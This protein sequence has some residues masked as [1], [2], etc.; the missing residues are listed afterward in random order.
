MRKY[1]GFVNIARPEFSMLLGPP[2]EKE[3]QKLIDDGA[4]L[5]DM[6]DWN[7]TFFTTR[8]S[9]QNAGDILKAAGYTCLR[10]FPYYS[11]GYGNDYLANQR[12]ICFSFQRP[13]RLINRVVNT[14]TQRKPSQIVTELSDF[15]FEKRNVNANAHFRLLLANWLLDNNITLIKS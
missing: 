9:A 11:T 3:V 15:L 13:D 7:Q 12:W 6:Q 10:D 5:K 4:C 1:Y 14:G 2:S 8:Q